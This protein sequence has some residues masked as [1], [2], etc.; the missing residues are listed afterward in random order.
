MKASGIFE[1]ISG[2]APDPSGLAYQQYLVLVISD[3]QTSIV[4]R[5]NHPRHRTLL[6]GFRGMTVHINFICA[7]LVLDLY[8]PINKK[9]K[10]LNSAPDR[11]LKFTSTMNIHFNTPT[12]WNPESNKHN[13]VQLII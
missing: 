9:Q 3:L 8:S 10:R 12:G 11:E 4:R 6:Q 7:Q 2:I 5:T 13:G 1:I